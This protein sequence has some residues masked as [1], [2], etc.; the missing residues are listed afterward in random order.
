MLH[1]FPD[2]SNVTQSAAEGLFRLFGLTV[3]AFDLNPGRAEVD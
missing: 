3:F 2:E 1:Y